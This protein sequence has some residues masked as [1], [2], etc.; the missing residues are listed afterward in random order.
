ML[1]VD[2]VIVVRQG[3]LL[4]PPCAVLVLP[5]YARLDND[6]GTGVHL[7]PTGIEFDERRLTLGKSTEVGGGGACLFCACG[8]STHML[9]RYC[10]P[11]GARNRVIFCIRC[12]V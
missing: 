3:A 2:K 10:A 6:V 11:L 5:M 4:M 9:T 1:V 7:T 8:S 12:L